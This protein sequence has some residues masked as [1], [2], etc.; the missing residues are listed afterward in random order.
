M[1]QEYHSNAVTT[2]NIR[3]QIKENSSTNTELADMFNTSVTTIRKW[4]NQEELEDKSSCPREI[5]SLA[6]W[7]F[8]MK[9]EI[10]KQKP[11][12]FKNKILAL[13]N[14]NEPGFH[15]QPCET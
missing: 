12:E 10:F 4:K 5:V 1:K 8:Y 6:Y 15:K 2:L 14:I 9:P 11:A 7:G 3:K 13:K